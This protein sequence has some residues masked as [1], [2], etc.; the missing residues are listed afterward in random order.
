MLKNNG[1]FTKIY[2]IQVNRNILIDNKNNVYFIKNNS[3]YLLS[4][5][6]IKSLTPTVRK[7]DTLENI[8]IRN[9]FIDKITN[10]IY[11]ATSRGPYI[12]K[13]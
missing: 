3:I 13:K 5:N 10:K 1:E 12:F 2:R 9:I 11:F 7:I 8:D 4:K 6:K